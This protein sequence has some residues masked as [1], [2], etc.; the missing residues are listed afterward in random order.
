VPDQNCLQVRRASVL[1][2]WVFF[3]FTASLV[4]IFFCLKN[5]AQLCT[6]SVG[7]PVIKITFGQND[8]TSSPPYVP[9]A[10][11]TYTSS[12]CPNDGFYT[13][14]NRTSNCFGNT[15]HT[16]LSDHTGG[17]NFLLINA[18]YVAGDVFLTTISGLCPN[19]SY[20]ISAWM[21]NVV[22]N[23]NTI[24]PEMIFRIEKP[25][26]TILAFYEPGQLPVSI[27][28]KW[29]QYGF[30]FTSPPD[31]SPVVLR[32]TDTWPGGV[33]N[34]FA[35]DDIAFRPCGPKITAS[36]QANADTVNICEGNSDKYTL[37]GNTSTVYPSPV[38]QWQLS[39]DSGSTWHDIAGATGDSYIRQPT[40]EAGN[41]SYRLTVVDASVASNVNC[42]IGS[43][44]V[45]I[46]V[47]PKPIVDAGPDRVYLKGNP[48]TISATAQGDNI[49]YY[50]EPTLYMSDP[51]SLSPTVS[52]PSDIMYTL[53]AQSARGCTNKDSVLVK[54]APGIF[55]PNAF[56]PND[57]GVNDQWRVTSLDPGTGAEVN[58]FNR[59]GQVVY[60]SS[61]GTVSWDGRLNG[62]PQPAGVY[63]YLIIFK[64]GNLPNMKGLVTLIR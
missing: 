6:S 5:S 61:G 56:T 52:P 24:K 54:Y 2:R 18:A 37:V 48:V 14:T 11:Y 15:W 28:P 64:K 62:N 26:G 49:S 10:G 43:N 20:E 39:K 38:Y 22:R 3:R 23:F 13:I 33:G 47:Y 27:E 17:G 31:N 29:E 34:D 51:N 50:W 58:V 7:D 53:S 35:I 59:W 12:P 55:V 40:A 44:V 30:V 57:D 32:I 19:T 16:I 42:R 21:M 46:N 1:S 4:I 60:H 36:I 63:V 25:D 9:S 8:I 45:V 41:Y